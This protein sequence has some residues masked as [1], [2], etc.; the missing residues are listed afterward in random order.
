MKPYRILI[1]GLLL[2][3][4]SGQAQKIYFRGGIGAAVTTAAD[5]HLNRTF[6]SDSASSRNQSIKTTKEGIGSGLPF[7]LA[8]GYM[9]NENFSVELGIDYFYGF[10]IKEKQTYTNSDWQWVS[11]SHGQMLSLVPA[12]ILT[13]PLNKI[14]PYARL[15]L[16]LGVLNSVVNVGS[17]PQSPDTINIWKEKDYGGLAIG[18]QTALGINYA[19]SEKLSLFAEIQLDAI[20]YSPK[21]G[22]YLEVKDHGVDLLALF[23]EKNKKWDYLKDIDFD[24]EIPN[25][26]P[27]EQVRVNYRF[28]NVGLIVGVKF[29]L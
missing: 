22:K 27:G 8:A 23:S 10:T 6:V 4:M 15:G 20:S 13:V 3:G 17:P 28:G 12:V 11:E 2:I 14:Q 21:H 1:I 5:I 25:D 26:Q 24:K 7:A 16:M 9:I 19:L 29:H 18:V